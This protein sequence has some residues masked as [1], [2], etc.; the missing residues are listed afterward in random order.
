MTLLEEFRV[1]QK[2][3]GAL[4][5][6][7]AEEVQVFEQLQ[8]DF[9][10]QY[11]LIFTDKMAPRSVV[12][13][14]SLTLDQEILQKIKGHFFY[15]ERMLCL[16]M[17]L[18]MPR[19]TITYIT[20]VPI[21][22]VIVDYYLHLLPG[23]TSYHAKQRLTLL[24]CFDA[25]SKSLTQ[26]ILERPRLIQ[27][28]KNSIP[29]GHP[30][31]ITCFNVTEK[32]QKLSVD[33]SIPLYGTSPVLNFLGTKTG[34]RRIFKDCGI[35]VPEGFENVKN[36]QEVAE[37]LTK[38]KMLQPGLRKAVVKLDDGFSGEGNAVFSYEN[39]PANDSLNQWIAEQLPLRLKIVAD[40]VTYSLYMKKFETMHGIVEAFIDGELKTSPSI[41]C[42]INPL[43]KTD[44]ISTHDQ[45][46]GGE[47]EQVFLGATFP[48]NREYASALGEI[49][50]KVAEELKK[51]GVLGRFGLDLMSVKEN[52][53]WKHYAIEI[54]LR[55]GG[56]THPYLMLQFLTDGDYDAAKGS[57]V[58]HDEK[59]RF[60]FATDN[61]Q[62]DC[63][64]G[65]TPHDL[66][67]IAMC[68]NLHYNSTTE[69]GV[70]F[71]LISALSQYGK[72]GLVCIGSTP[73]RAAEYYNKVVEVLN[74]ECE[75][76]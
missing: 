61:L 31:H 17:L 14:P 50:Y 7:E 28:I 32:E 69:E 33:L 1:Q 20:S 25:S 65:L 2:L 30:A 70:M 5:V 23:I 73:Q 44:V 64:K 72:L 60:Y 37:A 40:H 8:T 10:K 35:P 74:R 27:R 6:H 53:E 41:Q 58:M 47:D 45:V 9:R 67:D 43:G 68:N 39:A 3:P 4:S 18:R 51:Y 13:I 56:T 59:E 11:E 49:G 21:D 29:S 55:K 24:S 48:A 16:L 76:K 62:R 71:H 34:S 54:N 36:E 22:P 15:E 52:N 75:D 12:I 66:I 38:L 46:L 26:K 19:T 63:Y 57:Y 42:R